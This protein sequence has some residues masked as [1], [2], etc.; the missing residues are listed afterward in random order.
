[1]MYSIIITNP[2]LCNFVIIG[3][4]RNMARDLLTVTF[5]GR[6]FLGWLSTWHTHRISCIV[7]SCCTR[8]TF[9][10]IN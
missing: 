8:L 2:T 7:A 9:I 3:Y 1:M 10:N 6:I 5:Y 4:A